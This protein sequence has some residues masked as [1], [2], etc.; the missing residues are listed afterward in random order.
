MGHLFV[1]ADSTGTD[2]AAHIGDA[3]QFQQALDGAVLP[4]FAVEDRKD[5]I[6]REDGGLPIPDFHNAVD[7][8]VRGKKSL[9]DILRLLPFVF[10]DPVDRAGIAEPA[11]FFGDAQHNDVKRFMG[12]VAQHR[13]CGLQGDLI[14]CAGAAE[15]DGNGNLFHGE[16]LTPMYSGRAGQITCQFW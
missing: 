6:H 14:F 3:G 9:G 13:G 12:N 10:G 2:I 15:H 4:V 16:F 11:A 1:H 5:R 7:R 8:P